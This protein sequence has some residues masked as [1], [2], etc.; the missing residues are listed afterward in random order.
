MIIINICRISADRAY[1]EF[2]VETETN[3]KFDKLY[4]WSYK[5]VDIWNPTATT[6]DLSSYYDK[7]NNK[8]IK[9][10]PLA[11]ITSLDGSGLYYLQFTVL[12][13]ETGDE[14]TT[15]LYVNAVVADLSISYFAKVR[16]LNYSAD[17]NDNIIKLQYLHIYES[18]LK[19]AIS[20]GRYSD[21]NYYYE[22]IM[23]IIKNTT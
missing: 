16:L 17:Y 3:Y 13:D 1:L 19:S 21:A 15:P 14:V 9:Q 4:I 20:L 12:W 23:K 5:D 6:V 7:I 11:D 2:N 10:I 22:I 18:C 8:E